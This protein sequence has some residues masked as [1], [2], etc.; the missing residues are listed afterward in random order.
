MQSNVKYRTRVCNQSGWA[1][2]MGRD[3]NEG[4]CLGLTINWLGRTI[5]G[6][7]E[8]M[9]QNMEQSLKPDTKTPLVGDLGK[10]INIQEVHLSGKNVI[11][12][13]PLID[14]GMY[15]ELIKF[16]L[17]YDD[18]DSLRMAA[19]YIEKSQLEDIKKRLIESN[20]KHF[21]LGISGDHGGH[22]IGITTSKG[23]L[24]SK[25]TIFDSNAG[26]YDAPLAEFNAAMTE[27]YLDLQASYGKMTKLF[28]LFS[29]K[30]KKQEKH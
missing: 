8:E 21:I 17:E 12:L 3:I 26:R 16:G 4:V 20:N 18:K 2:A 28:T 9:W 19:P 15:D 10:A 14:T 6:K 1:K 11:G 30:E 22:A 25:V 24:N 27:N 5:K 29:L 23:V 13:S 7:E